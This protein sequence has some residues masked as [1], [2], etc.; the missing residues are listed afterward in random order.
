MIIHAA[1]LA[2]T[3]KDGY[4]YVAL[5]NSIA[6]SC[7][8]NTAMLQSVL[9]RRR[10]TPKQDELVTSLQR[11]LPDLETLLCWAHGEA[12]KLRGDETSYERTIEN[13]A[14]WK[15]KD[16][17]KADAEIRYETL[18]KEALIKAVNNYVTNKFN[19]TT[20]LTEDYEKIIERITS[21]QA[22]EGVEPNWNLTKFLLGSIQRNLEEYT[23]AE[24]IETVAERAGFDDEVVNEHILMIPVAEHAF[25]EIGAMLERVDEHLEQQGPE[26]DPNPE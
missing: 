23:T 18:P 17:L 24:G 6:W 2:D 22:K 10:R 19:R 14:G 16:E 15:S 11:D 3:I 26:M 25:E 1:A 21:Q 8:N 5:G 12:L 7:L 9:A 20:L 13:V 4:V